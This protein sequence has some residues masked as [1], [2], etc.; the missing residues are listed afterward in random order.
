MQP[1]ILWMR[2][3]KLPFLMA[4]MLWNDGPW[5]NKK[6][7][8]AMYLTGTWNV[9]RK[10]PSCSKS[11]SRRKNPLSQSCRQKGSSK[12]FSNESSFL[13][14]AT[15]VLRFFCFILSE[16]KTHFHHLPKDL[17]GQNSTQFFFSN[18]SMDLVFKLV[19]K[20]KEI[21][22]RFLAVCFNESDFNLWNLY[23]HPNFH[24]KGLIRKKPTTVPN[25]PT[26]LAPCSSKL[27]GFLQQAV[28]TW[29]KIASGI[30]LMV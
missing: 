23:F 3:G 22:T 28:G 12:A 5:T 19:F 9:A 6:N 2:H 1:F 16:E 25:T 26:S 4:Q 11:L 29:E 27:E 30:L 10:T 18:D 20:L 24:R 13:S 7:V 21:K 8:N 17:K 15:Q 14:A